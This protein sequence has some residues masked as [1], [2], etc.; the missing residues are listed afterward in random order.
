MA[1]PRPTDD[2]FVFAGPKATVDRRLFCFPYAGGSA[3]LFREWSNELPANIQV[4][5]IQLPGRQNRLAEKP[6]T[7]ISELVPVLAEAF[8]THCELPFAVFGHSMGALVA[9]E[10][11]RQLR[12]DNLPGPG[13]LFVS[14][15]MAP[16]FPRWQE[17][18]HE[19]SHNAFL[20]ALRHF[21][22]TPELLLQNAELMEMMSPT[23]RADFALCETY[24]YRDEP[25][26]NCPITAFGGLHAADVARFE[27]QAWEKQTTGDFKLEMFRGDH[28]FLHTDTKA[29]LE[30]IAVEMNAF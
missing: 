1:S 24:E 7:R 23:L 16:Q 15:Y 19:L 26:L 6:V 9:F 25:P 12:R 4:C 2:W 22:G 8:K 13:H 14:G 10:F 30:S 21:R 29:L 20:N 11:V 5:A 17:P 18:L 28:F 27:L 3:S